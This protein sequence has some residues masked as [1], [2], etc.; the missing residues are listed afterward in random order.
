MRDSREWR[1]AQ[2]GVACADA[3]AIAFAVLI[4]LAFYP[5]DLER[6]PLGC[7]RWT[8]AHEIGY[9]GLWLALIGCMHLYEYEQL[10]EGFQQY[11]RLARA[12]GYYLLLTGLVVLVAGDHFAPRHWLLAVW[13]LSTGL[14]GI[15]RWLIRQIVHWLRR[16]GI[17]Q[18][19]VLIVGAGEDGLAVAEQLM[20][21]AQGARRLLG[22]LDEYR[23]AGTQVG[24]VT[25]LGEPLA[26]A[27]VARA[28]GATE[29]IIVPQAI[30]WESLQVLLQGEP[31]EWGLQHVWL[32]PAFRDL[33]TT[34]MEVQ[35]H[36]ALPLVR[37]ARPRIVG[38]DAALKRGLDLGLSLLV[39]PIALPLGLIIAGWLAWIRRLPPLD[40]QPMV[41]RHQRAFC[42]YT[43]P[44]LPGLR[45]WHVWRL[46]VLLNLLR[47]EVSLV[48]P[49][50][51]SRALSG[52]Y[53]PWRVML[54]S[55][56]PGLTGPWWLMSGSWELSIADEVGVDLSYIRNYT[57]WTDFRLL[58]LTLRRL[59]PGARIDQQRDAD[60][61]HILFHPWL[62]AS[63]K[64]EER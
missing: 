10:I 36:G 58:A 21:H 23:A 33:L 40:G 46:P 53:R 24:S 16:Q 31:Q 20:A 26:L 39:L 61:Q 63:G 6:C 11:A 54:S 18:A 64:G 32:A 34:G 28:R 19:R 25:V 38:M 57:L 48:G 44:P 17:L 3:A 45:R 13:L 50:P 8:A 14:L 55:V 27:A 56:R 12:A 43:F 29:A 62:V 60:V 15:E 41:G 9:V 52:E 59:L 49:R 37:V 1:L 22:F 51:I 35:E 4:A 42:F 30:S 2:V 7:G 5:H 47:G